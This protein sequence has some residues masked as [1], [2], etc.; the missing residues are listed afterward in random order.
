M[1][2]KFRPRAHQRYSSLPILGSILDEFAEWSTQRG[3]TFLSV[4]YKLHVARHLDDLFRQFGV[5]GLSDLSH[6]AF[7]A[8]CSHYDRR[9]RMQF[10]GTINRIKQ[11]LEETGRLAPHR[12]PTTTPTPTKAE[13]DR[14]MDYLQ[15][16]RGFEPSTIGSHARY[17]KR[18]LEHLGYDRDANVLASL[19]GKE[20]EDFLCVCAR[21]F[22]RYSL[23]HVVAALR[24]FLRFQHEQGALRTPLHTRIDTP[25]VYRLE[26]LP[27]SLPWE[28]V[29]S[30][31][32]SIDRTN[33]TGIRDYAVLF[34]M[35]TYGLRNC[36]IAALTLDD[37]DWR[38]G[39]LRIPQ[40][41]TR[42]RLLLPLTDAVAEAL[43]DYLKRSRPR[44]PLS[45][46]CFSAFT[47]LM[48][49]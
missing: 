28:T 3:Y 2:S 22:N 6:N 45:R 17:S 26:Q 9:R 46:D 39:V 33:K 20:V 25:R 10:C 4:R 18:F 14:F 48:D 5:Q 37:I 35:A 31:L 32:L 44:V 1:I 12:P 42:S 38:A 11:F 13:V 41:K 34:L 8:A 40:K 49:H 21:Q 23:Q 15:K 24:A 27:R 19:T 16:V 47:P 30:L 29:N 43:I 7:E 36:E